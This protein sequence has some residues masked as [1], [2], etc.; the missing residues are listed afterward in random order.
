[1]VA[2]LLLLEGTAVAICTA[3]LRCTNRV[4]CELHTTGRIELENQVQ[5]KSGSV[6]IIL[7]NR[8]TN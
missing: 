7:F 3:K 6:K 2:T 4:A 8:I 1:M 5:C